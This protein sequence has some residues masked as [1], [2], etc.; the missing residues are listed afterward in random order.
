M[1]RT[2]PDPTANNRSVNNQPSQVNE[3]AEHRAQNEGNWYNP[4]MK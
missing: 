4:K 1:K 2:T 3:E